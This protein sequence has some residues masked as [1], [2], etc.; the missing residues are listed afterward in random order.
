MSAQAIARQAVGAHGGSI[1]VQDIPGK[2]CVFTV[3]VPA[4]GVEGLS[5]R[6]EQDPNV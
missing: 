5:E 6:K 4:T 2:G 1:R 3:E